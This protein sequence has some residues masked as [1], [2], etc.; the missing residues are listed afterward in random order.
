MR[1][2][3]PS[4][5]INYQHSPEDPFGINK[6]IFPLTFSSHAWSSRQKKKK[7]WKN[8]NGG[9]SSLSVPL[10]RILIP[11]PP[12]TEPGELGI[13]TWKRQ[14]D[15]ATEEFGNSS[16]SG[17]EGSGNGGKGTRPHTEG[18]KLPKFPKQIPKL[19]IGLKFRQE[20]CGSFPS[21]VFD[22]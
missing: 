1:G 15:F 5:V 16:R 11:E 12:N 17:A 19:L 7:G 9:E 20:T 8:G 21:T 10:L 2:S 6:S 4:T 13:R 3:F 14:V 18:R 22:N